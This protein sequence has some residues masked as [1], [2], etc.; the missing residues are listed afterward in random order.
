MPR[1]SRDDRRASIRQVNVTC[2]SHIIVLVH[3]WASVHDRPASWACNDRNSALHILRPA[4]LPVPAT[5]SRRLRSLAVGVLVRP[6]TALLRE[7][8]P[9]RL[10]QELLGRPLP[11]GGAS[12]GAGTVVGTSV[13]N[14]W[15]SFEPLEWP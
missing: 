15:D 6:L 14:P 8:L 3:L 4:R 9:S 2:Q 13:G 11:V 7:V 12:I 10:V 1:P 5:L